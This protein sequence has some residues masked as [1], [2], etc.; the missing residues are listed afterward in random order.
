MKHKVLRYVCVL[1][2]EFAHSILKDMTGK[3][4]A[5]AD[6]L[7]A[8]PKTTLKQAASQAYGHTGNLAEVTGYQNIRKP[9]IVAYL[10]K[11]AEKAKNKIVQLVDS[12]KEDI[13]LRASVDIMD[14]VHGKATQRIEQHTTGVVLTID[15]TSALEG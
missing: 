11:H 10:D 2:V 14:R 4:K 7:I 3:Q 8:D 6:A 15:L 9:Q 12:E 5:F 13:A 1:L